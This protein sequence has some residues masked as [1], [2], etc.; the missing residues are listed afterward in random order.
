LNMHERLSHRISAHYFI[1]LLRLVVGDLII[2]VAS[3][4]GTRMSIMKDHAE[5]YNSRSC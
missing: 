1:C 2:V 5:I 3:L 4:V